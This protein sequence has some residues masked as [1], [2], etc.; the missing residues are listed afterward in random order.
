MMQ[1]Y[2]YI[3]KACCGWHCKVVSTRLTGTVNMASVNVECELCICQG[4]CQ[5]QQCLKVTAQY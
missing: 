1:K 4:S 3:C 5:F 2:H